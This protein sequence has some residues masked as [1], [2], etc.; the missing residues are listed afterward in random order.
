M[1]RIV[2]RVW[3]LG[4]PATEHSDCHSLENSRPEHRGRRSQCVSPF[5]RLAAASGLVNKT[6]WEFADG[7]SLKNT[8]GA[9]WNKTKEGL[10]N[11]DN[12]R[13]LLR[14]TNPK[15]IRTS[16]PRCL[17]SAIGPMKCS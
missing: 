14:D 4:C 16:G 12:T 5:A 17:I 9:R 15:N 2:F 13:L 11:S 10:A 8:F 3:S 1:A 6:T 7:L